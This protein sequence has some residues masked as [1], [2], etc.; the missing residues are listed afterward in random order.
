MFARAG[1]GATTRASFYTHASEIGHRVDANDGEFSEI[2]WFTFAD[3]ANLNLPSITRTIGDL[4]AILSFNLK[5]TPQ[6]PS[7]STF[8]EAAYLNAECC[9]RGQARLDT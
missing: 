9:R 7:P 4:A 5:P 8:I 3:A 2:G 6:N 1:R